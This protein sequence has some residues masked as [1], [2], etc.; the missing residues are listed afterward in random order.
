MKK[1]TSRIAM[2]RQ[3]I[4]YR[5]LRIRKAR[6]SLW[7]FCRTESPDFYKQDRWHLKVYAW[8]LQALYEGQ[9][10]KQ[11]F[12]DFCQEHAPKSFIGNFD[13]D[14]LQE[15][16]VYKKLMTNLP[17]QHGKS[18][19]LVNFCKWVF[20]R[21]PEEKIITCSYNDDVAGD[22]SRYTRDG[23]DEEKNEPQDIVYSDI[24]PE[25]RIKEGNASFH[26]WA[27]EGQHFSYI[28]AGVGGSITS[29]GATILIVDDPIKDAET[30]LNEHALDKIW[31]WYTGTFLS[32]VAARGGEPIEI[33]NMTRWSKKDICGRILAGP[34]AGE[35]F[36]LKMEAMDAEGNML[37]TELLS[38]RRYQSLKTN[39]PDM[40][41]RAN[42]HQEPIDIQGRLYKRFKTY[43]DIP[44]D[45]QG[46][47][48][49]EQII[50]YTDTADT[51]S[52][53]LCAMAAGVYRGE[54]YVLD[55]YYTQEGMEV[56][57]PETADFLVR[58]KV[59]VAVIESNNGGRGFARNVERLIW[60]RHKTRRVSV[61]WFH[62]SKNKTAR[63]LANSNFVMEHVYFP[64][65][66]KDRW[67]EYYEAMTTY[68]KEGKNKHDDAPDCTTGLAEMLEQSIPIP[69]ETKSLLKGVSLYG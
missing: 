2:E 51:G 47:P 37:C 28:G 42:Y 8:V 14:R 19:T 27:L 39:V 12:W 44:R 49:F 1:P 24:F 7:E 13:W 17:P 6:K 34:E 5:E 61:Q 69:E 64:V 4:L 54:A 22:F 26:K 59:S 58:N 20:G 52:D 50:A 18:R 60:E 56:T 41:F 29:K 35:W 33:V 3:L 55:V 67:P 43:E 38:K 62:Q 57:E 66:W 25:V 23:I 15:G 30:A 10:T 16:R 65:N 36:V 63:I 46:N 11:S 21:N 9:L 45:E 32:R 68:Q 48:L 31:L 53:F 40:I